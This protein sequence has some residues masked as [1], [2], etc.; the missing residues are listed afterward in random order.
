MIASRFS[1]FKSRPA[2]EVAEKLSLARG[3]AGLRVSRGRAGAA[4][5]RLS[6][7]FLPGRSSQHGH[8][9]SQGAR[10]EPSWDP[11]GGVSYASK[12]A[13]RLCEAEQNRFLGCPTPREERG[14]QKPAEQESLPPPGLPGSRPTE[15]PR[16]ANLPRPRPRDVRGGT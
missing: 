5:Q 7:L 1:I 13:I 12:P 14:G 9:G 16:N 15:L 11:K 2:P 3:T 4:Q 10:R 6:Y 8:H